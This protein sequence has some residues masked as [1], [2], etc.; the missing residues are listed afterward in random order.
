[1]TTYE[2]KIVYHTN[3]GVSPSSEVSQ[4]TTSPCSE[5]KNLKLDEVSEN[6]LL[7]SWSVSVCGNAIQI[8][9]YKVTLKGNLKNLISYYVFFLI[10]KKEKYFYFFSS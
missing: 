5:P 4:I 10:E 8:D 3:F 9:R 1:M 2:F 7:V 6:A